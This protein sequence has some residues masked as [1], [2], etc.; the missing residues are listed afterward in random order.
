MLLRH[1]LRK[2]W[3]LVPD[4]VAVQ[5]PHCPE[6]ETCCTLAAVQ[7][8]RFHGSRLGTAPPTLSDH[9]AT[10]QQAPTRRLVSV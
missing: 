3:L 5:L 10:F 4:G 1:R 7:L 2:Y 8:Q 6:L 9:W